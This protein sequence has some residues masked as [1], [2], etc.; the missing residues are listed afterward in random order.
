MN[1]PTI[2]QERQDRL[3][4]ATQTAGLDAILL[5]PGPSLVYFTGLAFHLSERP[6]L[7]ALAPGQPL[8]IILPELETAKVEAISYPLQAFPYGEDPTTW[9]QVVNHALNFLDI[10]GAKIG[11]EP[12]GLRFLE[13]SLLQSALPKVDFTDAEQAVASL[14]R[15]KDQKEIESMQKAA[16]IA[17][18]ALRA[19]LPMI[20]AG[21]TEADIA[22]ELFM[23]LVHHGSNPVNP[24]SPIVSGGPNSANP[25][26]TPSGRPLSPGDLLVIDYGAYIEGY[27]SDITRTFAIE[28]IDPELQQIAAIVLQAN[29]AA[30]SAIK[31]GVTAHSVD[32]AARSIIDSTG[33]GRYFTHRTGHGLGMEV[34]EEPYI[35]TGNTLVLETGM[36]FT[37]EPGIY[38]PSRNGVRIEDNVLVTPTGVHTFT[39]LPR[40]LITLPLE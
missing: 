8:T 11:I 16:D 19:T 32:H 25:H 29:Q 9:S 20:N 28:S 35:R 38:L 7:V 1:S 13:L 10:D 18:D 30:R 34:H 40:A 14:R 4:I 37:I 31:P 24:F 26:A 33:Y 6:V 22:A 5:N 15:I 3:S 23:Q 2:F 12:R 27:F 36:T 39:S 21:V 17:Q